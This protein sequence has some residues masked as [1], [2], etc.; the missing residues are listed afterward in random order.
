MNIY[1]LRLITNW[2]GTV[3]LSILSLFGTNIQEDT[4]KIQ[5]TTIDNTVSVVSTI[6][7][8]QTVEKYNSKLPS[9]KTRILVEG[10]DGIT[11]VDSNGIE[12]E[13]RPV[14]DRII[15]IGTG[16]SSGYIGNTT[17]YGADCIGCSGNVSCKT[18]EGTTHNIVNDGMYYDDA[19]YGSVRI[20]AA[21]HRVFSC[22]TI[23]EVDNGREEPFL[24]IVL[25]TGIDMRKN[26]EEYGLIHIDV[27]FI[28]EKDPNVYSMTASNQS[29]KF[30]VERW[31]W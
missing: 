3:C 12:Q 30:N 1:L 4:I 26:W 13:L 29:A 14:V 2:L 20:L 6:T 16:P 23:I 21:D 25:D 17:G 27:A 7:E 10:N 11:Y 18:R 24:G 31:G 19:Q 15:E 5:N 28:S 8:H 22:G 9:G